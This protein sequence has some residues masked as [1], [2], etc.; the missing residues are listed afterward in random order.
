[1]ARWCLGAQQAPVLLIGYLSSRSFEENRDIDRLLAAR[2]KPT[3]IVSDNGTELT[4]NAILRW[5]D[6]NKVAWHYIGAGQA[7]PERVHRV[8]SSAAYKSQFGIRNSELW[9]KPIDRVRN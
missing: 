6:D 5:A 2:A 3:T 4:S 7:D 1:M 8:R 9:S